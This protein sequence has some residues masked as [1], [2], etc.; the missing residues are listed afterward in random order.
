MEKAKLASVGYCD[1]AGA[2]GERDGQSDDS[3]SAPILAERTGPRVRLAIDA[4][5]AMERASGVN[6]T[7]RT[8]SPG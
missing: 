7:T 2:S 1:G 6:V 4:V 3:G 5:M 8:K